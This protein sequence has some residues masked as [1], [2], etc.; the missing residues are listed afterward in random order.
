VGNSRKSLAAKD[1]MFL[2][3]SCTRDGPGLSTAHRS[4]D[5]QGAG[6]VNSCNSI[7]PLNLVV[8]ACAI[9]GVYGPRTV[10]VVAFKDIPGTHE[11]LLQVCRTTTSRCS[12]DRRGCLQ[13]WKRCCLQGGCRQRGATP[14]CLLSKSFCVRLDSLCLFAP[15]PG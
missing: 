9:M 13:L 2:S 8:Q 4:A 12:G 3:L 1:G 10:F 6:W 15:L 14:R 5:S 7:A 11:F